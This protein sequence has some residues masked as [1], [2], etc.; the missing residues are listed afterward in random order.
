MA[1]VVK[2]GES[3]KKMRVIVLCHEDLVP[4]DT[5]DDLTTK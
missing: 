4:P 3:F 2:N 5:I 1:L